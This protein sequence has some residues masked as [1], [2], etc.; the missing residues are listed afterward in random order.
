M[1]YAM[2]IDERKLSRGTRDYLYRVALQRLR[3]PSLAD[4]AVQEALLAAHQS[5][6]HFADRSAVRTWLVG[7]LNHKIADL[8]RLRSRQACMECTRWCDSPDDAECEPD[9][10]ES[11]WDEQ[12]S[13]ACYNPEAAAQR[14]EFWKVFEA[15]LAELPE[16]AANAFYLKE[17]LGESI[18]GIC[19]QLDLGA[20]HCAVMLFRTRQRLRACLAARGYGVPSARAAAR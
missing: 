4:D 12:A 1:A 3:D 16:R 7:I 19:E 2:G 20:S 10:D 8:N 5:L 11:A 17:V 9:S 18:D 15:C 13:N 14:R 6:S